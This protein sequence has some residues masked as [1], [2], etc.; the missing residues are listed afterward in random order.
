MDGYVGST[1]WSNVPTA[2]LPIL[3]FATG[4]SVGY[5]IPFGLGAFNIEIV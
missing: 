3:A 4:I 1:V 5:N 2:Y